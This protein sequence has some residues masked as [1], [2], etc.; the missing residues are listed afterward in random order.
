[1]TTN[2]NSTPDDER[3]A[4]AE[5]RVIREWL[6]LSGPWLAAHLDVSDRTIRHWESGRYPIPDGVRI[7]IERIEDETTRR[8]DAA[9]TELT[10]VPDPVLVTYASDTQHQQAHPDVTYPASWHRAMAARVSYRVPGLSIVY[11]EAEEGHQ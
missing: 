3:M 2:D 8:V 9:V 4:P 7:E 10:G 11:P 6:G 5:F 1:M